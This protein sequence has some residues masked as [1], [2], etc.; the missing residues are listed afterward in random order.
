MPFVAI[1][2]NIFLYLG[3]SIKVPFF[4]NRSLATLKYSIRSFK[5]IL[6]QHFY[7]P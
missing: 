7:K 2:E 4:D 6:N 1:L 3:N 5:N